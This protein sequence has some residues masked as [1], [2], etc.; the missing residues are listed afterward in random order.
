MPLMGGI[1]L[2]QKVFEIQEHASVI[3]MSGCHWSEILPH[4]LARL[5]SVLEK[6]FTPAMLIAAVEKGLLSTKPENE[7][8]AP[9]S[10]GV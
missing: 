2:L 1:E 10:D 9:R 6:P 8:S 3:I 4:H 5:S 7:N